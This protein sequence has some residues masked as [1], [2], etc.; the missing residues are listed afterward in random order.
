MCSH[1]MKKDNGK[2]PPTLESTLPSVPLTLPAIH[3]A[4]YNPN[5]TVDEVEV[6][7]TAHPLCL[8]M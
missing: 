4:I 7:V 2:A 1:E 3:V 5:L 8:G 6:M